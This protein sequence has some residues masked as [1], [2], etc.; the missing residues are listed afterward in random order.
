VQYFKPEGETQFVG[1]CMPFFHEGVFHLF[2]L[3]DEGHHHARGGLGCHQWAHSTTTDLVHWEHHGL[4]I[5]I[6]HER[7]GSICTG[8]VFY[9]DGVYR[10]YYATRYPDWSEHLSLAV[11]TDGIHFEKTEPNPF[12]SPGPEYAKSFRDPHLFRDPETGLFH[13]LVTTSLREPPVQGR[14]G[15][16][17]QLVS[18]DLHQW[19]PAEPLIFPGY[20]G[21]PECPDYVV[22]A[23]A[24]TYGEG[25]NGW[26]YVI[27]SNEGVA[28][29]RM[30]RRPLGPWVRPEVDTF[31]GSMARVMK[32]AAFTGGRRIGVAF[33]PSLQDG[34]DDGAW[35][36]AGNA[37]FREIIQHEDGTL[38]TKWP[39]E[40]I[41]TSGPPVQL[42][43]EGM[44]PGVSAEGDRVRIEAPASFGAAVATAVPLNARVQA[45]IEPQPGG[46]CFGVC[47]RG[48][49]RYEQGYEIRVSPGK[50]RVEIRPPQMGEVA[51]NAKRAIS[52]VEGLDRPFGLDVVLKDDIIDVCIDERRTLVARCPEQRGE[53]LFLF[54]HCGSVAF[55]QIS[56]RPLT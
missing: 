22:G 36:Y 44:T 56:V 30:S 34:R 6:T 27:F 2:W 7:E 47:V 49:G 8:S 9:H 15:C 10:A 52:T 54:A 46:S 45:R 3:L 35:L 14:G 1:D 53:R 18:E 24:P 28:R 31:D 55:R 32:T 23:G 39:A 12:A 41:P 48:S 42:A 40:M 19:R 17:A 51:D 38:G 33:L 29:Y 37:L 50:R 13:L 11:S 5:P 16:L 4:A 20:L 21:D 43:F 25:W 26:Y